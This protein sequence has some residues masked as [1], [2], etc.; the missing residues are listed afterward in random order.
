MKS[1]E[2]SI[3]HIQNK[4]KRP[5]M[6]ITVVSKREW[7]KRPKAKLSDDNFLKLIKSS[8]YGFKKYY[9]LKTVQIQ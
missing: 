6:G 5:K 2:E 7:E 8:V 9:E 1:T 4:V 3:T